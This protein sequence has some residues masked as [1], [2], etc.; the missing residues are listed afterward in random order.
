M[1]WKRLS[2]ANK[3]KSIFKKV[4]E[5]DAHGIKKERRQVRPYGKNK[6]TYEKMFERKKLLEVIVGL[7]LIDKSQLWAPL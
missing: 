7:R 6:D 2:E 5:I 3:E 1:E 4:I